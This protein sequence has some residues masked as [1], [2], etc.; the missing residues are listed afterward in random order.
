VVGKWRI[1][2]LCILIDTR[3][4]KIGTAACHF[5]NFDES[6]VAFFLQTLG[7]VAKILEEQ[8]QNPTVS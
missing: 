1:Y 5:Y 4:N 6:F 3:L 8:P 7:I 2:A